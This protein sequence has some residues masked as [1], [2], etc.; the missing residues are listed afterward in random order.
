[1]L[2]NEQEL[3]Q[4]VKDTMGASYEKVSDDGFK[5][6]VLQATQEL[7]WSLPINDPKKEFWIV[8]RTKRFVIYILLV[9]SADKFQYKKIFLQHRFQQYLQLLKL[10]DEEFLRALETSPELFDT[11]TY[12]N[13]C[14][15]ITTGFSYDMAGNDITPYF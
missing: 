7:N 4:F 9:E 13:L 2:N 12:N 14:S 3:V 11:N 6:A 1:M 15:Y 8:E 5:R 10:M